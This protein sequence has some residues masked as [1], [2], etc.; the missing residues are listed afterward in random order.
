[1]VRLLWHGRGGPRAGLERAQTC[2][3]ALCARQLSYENGRLV[4]HYEFCLALEWDS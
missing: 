2:M 4:G 3:W 1:V